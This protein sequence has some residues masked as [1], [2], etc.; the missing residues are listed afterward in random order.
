MLQGLVAHQ[1][2]YSCSPQALLSA[3]TDVLCASVSALVGVGKSI[4]PSC[5]VWSSVKISMQVIQSFKENVFKNVTHMYHCLK[6][7]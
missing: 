3:E 6:Y 2:Q 4:A 1:A 7:S 5:L